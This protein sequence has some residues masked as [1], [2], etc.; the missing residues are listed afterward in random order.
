MA[1][2]RGV[3]GPGDGGHEYKEGAWSVR[4]QGWEVRGPRPQPGLPGKEV[5]EGL[6]AK[7]AQGSPKPRCPKNKGAV[8]WDRFRCGNT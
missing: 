7:K 2:P 6:G 8:S 5:G 1:E 4:H 3:H